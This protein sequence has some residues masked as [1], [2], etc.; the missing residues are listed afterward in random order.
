MARK[1]RKTYQRKLNKLI[2]TLNQNIAEDNLWRGR[3]YFFQKD[4]N[5]EEYSDGSGGVLNAFIRAYDKATGYYKDYQL[6]YAPYFSFI[7]WD[8]WKIGNVFITEDCGVWYENPRPSINTAK[9]WTKIA[10]DTQQI[11][12]LE[13]NFYRKEMH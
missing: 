1:M 5:W 3:F 13:W 9:D 11:G 8:V 2:R 7:N 4:A 12:K 6:S 10:V